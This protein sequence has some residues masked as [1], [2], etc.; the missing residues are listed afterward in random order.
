MINVSD[1][2]VAINYSNGTRIDL[3]AKFNLSKKDDRYQTIFRCIKYLNDQGYE[4][5]SSGLY[6]K[7][8]YFSGSVPQYNNSE[9]LFKKKSK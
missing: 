5:Q 6:L 8:A 4:L 3:F 7:Y 1:E 2:E 9:Y